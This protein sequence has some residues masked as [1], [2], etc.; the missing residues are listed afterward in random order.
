M[1]ELVREFSLIDLFYRIATSAGSIILNSGGVVRG[2]TNWGICLL[3]NSV[4]K[5]QST[6]HQGHYFL[7][8]FDSSVKAQNSLRKTLDLDPRMVRHSVVKMGNTLKSIKDIGGKVEWK[9]AE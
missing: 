1:K 2:I 4:R 8:R 5:H 9:T 3:P 7:M 6:Y